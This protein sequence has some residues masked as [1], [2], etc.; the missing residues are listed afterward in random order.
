MI[1]ANQCTDAACP[2]LSATETLHHSP[3][4]PWPLNLD[5]NEL[6][7]YTWRDTAVLAKD[8]PNGVGVPMAVEVGGPLHLE[9]EAG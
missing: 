8:G 2:P 3:L 1:L 5:T 4:M 9:D 7:T 6:T